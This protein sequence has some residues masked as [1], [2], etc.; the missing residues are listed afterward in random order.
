MGVPLILVFAKVNLCVYFSLQ[1]K[2]DTKFTTYMKIAP[3]QLSGT[4][5]LIVRYTTREGERK[6]VEGGSVT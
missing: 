2:T 6:R 3:P 5:V 1:I 4:Y